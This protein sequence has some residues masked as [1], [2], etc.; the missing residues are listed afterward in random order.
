[1]AA[2]TVAGIIAQWLQIEPTLSPSQVKNVI[3]ETAIKDNYTQDPIYGM[4][5]GPNGKIDALAGARYL[6][7][8]KPQ[9]E[10]ILGD[11]NDDGIINITDVTRLTN[12]LLNTLLE[13][14][15]YQPNE[16]YPINEANADY[17]QDGSINVTDLVRLINHVLNVID[18]DE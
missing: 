1:M 4:H 9:P 15:T 16:E 2:P 8:L 17:N 11:V 13:D 6:I 10:P 3:A 14:G 18:D 12:Y 7:S 5:F